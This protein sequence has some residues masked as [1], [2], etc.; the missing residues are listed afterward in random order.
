MVKTYLKKKLF[1]E[2]AWLNFVKVVKPSRWNVAAKGNLLWLTKNVLL[3]GLQLKAT[4]LVMCASKRF[5]TY[6]SL[7]YEYKACELEM[8]EQTEARWQ[9]SMDTGK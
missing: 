2:F 8:V 6:L 1:V 3:N 7:S 5:R 4:K 9:I